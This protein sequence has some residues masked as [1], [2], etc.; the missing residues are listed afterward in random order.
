MNI[1][2]LVITILVL[3][4]LI[5]L[6]SIKPV[7]SNLSFF[8]LERRSALGNET[9][10]RA[11]ERERLRSD[12]LSLQKVLSALFLVVFVICCVAV[13]GNPTGI[14]LSVIVALEYGAVARLKMVRFFPQKLY[15]KF[16]TKIL[17]I[18][19]K[20]PML[21]RFLSVVSPNDKLSNSFYLGSRE[22]LQYIIDKSEGV[23]SSDEKKLIVNSLSFNDMLVSS[24]MTPRSMIESISASE[25]LGPITLDELHA[26]H[27]R[28][29]VIKGDIDHIVGILNLRSLLSLDV[30]KSTTA[31]KAM[32]PKVCY[33]R[34][35]QSLKHALAAFLKT[36]HQLFVVVNEFQETV[37][38]L[39]LED[40]IEALI[41]QEI[42]DEFDEHDDL[43]AVALHNPNQN[44]SPQKRQNV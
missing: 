5:A 39:S 15:N 41:G 32:D 26:G 24:T 8:E 30:K 2:M 37:G 10:A 1:F 17:K 18:I 13:F 14:L 33:I 16:E 34:Q 23:L 19:K 11:L 7:S 12:V 25:F 29:P 43:R 4:L 20:A 9:A 31:E 42:I 27:T 6:A 44:N 3:L 22:E 28:L 36:R 35:D 40:V 38:L 21:M